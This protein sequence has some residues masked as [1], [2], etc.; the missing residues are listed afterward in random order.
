MTTRG[1]RWLSPDGRPH[2][3]TRVWRVAGTWIPSTLELTDDEGVTVTVPR[4]EFW[5]DW[6][7]SG[8]PRRTDD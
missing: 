2:T 1:E 6:K 8:E 5:R 3:I 7:E 4:R